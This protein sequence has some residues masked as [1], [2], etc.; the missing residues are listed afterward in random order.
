[1]AD[2]KLQGEPAPKD[3]EARDADAPPT[4]RVLDISSS[5][6][7]SDL[8]CGVDRTLIEEYLYLIQQNYKRADV[9][10][11]FL[12]ER[13]NVV[14]FQGITNVRDVLSHLVTLLDPATPPERQAGQIHNAEEHLR[15]AINEPYEVALHDLIV[16]FSRV[17]QDYKEKVLPVKESYAALANAP[18]KDEIETTMR[19]VRQLIAKGRSSKAKN[20][21]NEE[22]EEGVISF[23]EAYDSLFILHL[24]IERYYHQALQIL[25]QRE[26]AVTI[27]NLKAEVAKL[28]GEL[29]EVD[30]HI[31]QEG[32][33]GRRLHFGGYALAVLLAIGGVILGA[34][35]AFVFFYL[36]EM[37]K[38]PLIPPVAP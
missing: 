3:G 23:T 8:I 5:S 2:K 6:K 1:M 26:E 21:W 17:Y 13:R 25:E 19:N 15:R 31:K 28:Q 37:S 20:M 24:T 27:K 16:E 34:L 35:I 33:T 18:E 10:M 4:P 30:K 14:N 9:A 12:E 11:F 32:Q 38:A 29:T 7:Q 36:A 22:W